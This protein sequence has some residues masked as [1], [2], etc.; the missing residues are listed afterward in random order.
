LKGSLGEFGVGWFPAHY[1]KRNY[2]LRVTFSIG[3]FCHDKSFFDASHY[4]DPEH[5]WFNAFYGSYGLRSYKSDGTAW[6]FEDHEGKVLNMDEVHD[7]FEIDYNHLTA[8]MLGCP[9]TRMCARA[10]D[11]RVSYDVNRHWHIV[12]MVAKAPSGWN[13]F[14]RLSNMSRTNPLYTL[15]FG[16]PDP[17]FAEHVYHDYPE[18]QLRAKMFVAQVAPRTTIVFGG[19]FRDDPAGH[20]LLDEC[21]RTMVPQFEYHI[22]Q[23]KVL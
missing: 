6:C 19:L 1:V 5:P 7:V 4:Y 16:V 3:D 21:V 17:S 11:H 9:S 14:Y 12:D 15:V 13:R 2:D 10:I 20:A 18:V 8:G 23:A 22:R